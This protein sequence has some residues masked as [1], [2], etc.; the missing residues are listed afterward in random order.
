MDEVIANSLIYNTQI[1]KLILIIDECSYRPVSVRNS[2]DFQKSSTVHESRLDVVAVRDDITPEDTEFG[3][4]TASPAAAA[5]R[6]LDL[7][8][9]SMYIPDDAI[10]EATGVGE[11]DEDKYFNAA[12]DSADEAMNPISPVRSTMVDICSPLKSPPPSSAGH[13]SPSG[14]GSRVATQR[15]SLTADAHIS[16]AAKESLTAQM[17]GPSGAS[18][19]Q[20]RSKDVVWLLR[21]LKSTD[22]IATREDR[23]EAVQELKALIKHGSVSFWER[24]F[25]QVDAFAFLYFSRVSLNYICASIL[26]I[27]IYVCVDY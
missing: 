11:D 13:K 25:A 15:N 9:S 8:E 2:V 10:L 1:T 20:P 18:P 3:G 6:N 23:L 4:P 14:S 19:I 26:G 27:Y 16:P 17:L 21:V 24:N 22:Y 7:A 12:A 5:S